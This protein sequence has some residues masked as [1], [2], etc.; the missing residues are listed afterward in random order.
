MSEKNEEEDGV[1][2]EITESE[3]NMALR[4]TQKD[5]LKVVESYTRKYHTIDSVFL[6]LMYLRRDNLTVRFYINEKN[7]YS[8]RMTDKPPVGFRN[9]DS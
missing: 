2:E 6:D 9:D 5:Y 7:E 1:L 4:A 8:Y 3:F